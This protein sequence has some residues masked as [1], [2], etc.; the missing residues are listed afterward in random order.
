MVIIGYQ[1][2]GK[3]TLA[4][5]HN[6]IDLESSNFFDNGVRP[7]DWYVFY[8]NIAIHLSEQGYTVFTSSHKVVRDYLK[9]HCK[10]P[11]YIICP[12]TT[13]KDEWVNKLKKRY[14]STKLDK[15]YKAL[16]NANYNYKTNINELTN[17]GINVYQ[18]M[19]MD[20]S[21]RDILLNI[22]KRGW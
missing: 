3:S 19:S 8:C 20:Y 17:C 15:D 14:E 16:M 9:E 22:N 6:C 7:D 18:I 4:G 12:S 11:L 10:E 13:L 2:I 1:G 21:L 5:K